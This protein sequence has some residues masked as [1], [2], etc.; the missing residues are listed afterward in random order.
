MANYI[1]KDC[2]TNIE[3]SST[4]VVDDSLTI[5]GVYQLEITDGGTPITSCF[6]IL[7]G[8]SGSYSATTLSDAF[9]ICFNCLINLPRSANTESFVCYDPCD[10]GTPSLFT[11]PHPVWTDGYGTSVTQLNAITLGGPNGLNA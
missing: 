9:D 7:T 4:T 10:T 8:D 1:Y 11:A 5:N 6:T 3:Y 2:N